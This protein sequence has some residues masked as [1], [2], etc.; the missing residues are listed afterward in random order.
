MATPFQ[1]AL[2]GVGYNPNQIVAL[3]LQGVSNL[4]DLAML[5]EQNIRDMGKRMYE[6]G[7]T[8]FPIIATQKLIV[9][10]YWRRKLISSG[11]TANAA[12][13]TIAMLTRES[14]AYQ[15]HKQLKEDRKQA[16]AVVK[17]DKFTKAEKWRTFH[18]ALKAYLQGLEGISNV[19]LVYVIRQ[20][21][22]PP[23]NA[24]YANELQR[25]IANAPLTGAAFTADNH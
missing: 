13:I 1:N 19:P 6:S 18:D 8:N 4:D 16:E 20:D 9:I 7:Q 17:P 15:S 14:E 12:D 21:A 24:A 2:F 11:Q 22:V 10:H 3:Q 5:T 23:P 25:T